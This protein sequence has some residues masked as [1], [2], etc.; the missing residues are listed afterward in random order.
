MDSPIF[1]NV[2]KSAKRAIRNPHVRYGSAFLTFL[3]FG[4]LG[5]KEFAQIRYDIKKRRGKSLEFE[6][7]MKKSGLDKKK[8]QTLEEIFQETVEEKEL[9][10][11]FNIRGPRQGEDS[12]EIQKKQRLDYDNMQESN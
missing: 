6:Q 1:E 4:F 2:M 7:E 8:A 3:V 9:D 11:W 5:L 10:D 12:R